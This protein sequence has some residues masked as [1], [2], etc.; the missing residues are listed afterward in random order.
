MA[1]TLQEVIQKLLADACVSLKFQFM[2]TG[3]HETRLTL[4]DQTI[5]DQEDCVKLLSVNVDRQLNFK[6]H[7]NEVCR[8]AG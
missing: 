4:N 2:V 3:N 7:V 1:E 5:L 8:K 6:F